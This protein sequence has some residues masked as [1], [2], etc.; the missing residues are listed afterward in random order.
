MI[1]DIET[2]NYNIQITFNNQI[3]KNKILFD[4]KSL[5]IIHYPQRTIQQKK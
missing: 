3:I 2:P 1:I 4:F 5:I